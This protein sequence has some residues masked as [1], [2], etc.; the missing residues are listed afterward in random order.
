MGKK[1]PVKKIIT[2]M[3]IIIIAIVVLTYLGRVEPVLEIVPTELNFGDMETKKSFTLLNKGKEKWKILSNVK[4]LQYEID[5]P[6]DIEWI[7]IPLKSGMC[8]K[9]EEKNVTVVINRDKLSVGKNM[10][11]IEAKS[12]GGNKTI[13]IVAERIK[14]EK[15]IKIMRPHART[16]LLMDNEVTIQWIATAN[17]GNYVDILLLLNDSIIETIVKSYNYRNDDTSDG[18]YKWTPKSP[19][20]PGEEKY[21]IRIVDSSDKN[22]FADV[23]LIQIVSPIT[24]LFLKN[25][26]TAHQKPST[27]QFIFSLRDQNNRAVSINPSAFDL[28]NLKIWE[29]NEEID[30]HE[31]S[32]FLYTQ[33]DFQM[34]V[35]LVLDFSAS[36]QKQPNGVETM[37]AGANSLIDNL[38]E[39]HQIGIVE[40]HRPDEAPS[41]I[42]PFTT[43]KQHAKESIENFST[44]NI[45]SDFSICWDAAYQ[46]LKQ[47]PTG[48]DHKIFRALVFISDGFDNSSL[49]QPEDLILLANKE[50]IHIYN[51]GLGN[52]RNESILENI[53]TKT[54]GTYIRAE[55][56][57]FF[58]ERFKQIIDDLGGQYKISYIT[59][60]R[61]EDGIFTVKGEITY[62]GVTGTPPLEDL[63]DPS[64]IFGKTNQGVISFE[65]SPFIKGESAEIFMWCEHTPRYVSTFRFFL[66][67]D[68]PYTISLVPESD[69]GI[70]KGW[71]IIKAEDGWYQLNSPNPRDM[72]HD[73]E[74][75]RSGIICKIIL[76]EIKEKETE[77]SFLLD[78][79]VYPRRQTFYGRDASE[80]DTNK[81]WSKTLSISKKQH[82]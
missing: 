42:Q 47:F 27:I 51:I 33:D 35:M 62:K 49:K 44:K 24:K 30:Y 36:M 46:G 70:C 53:S 21:T 8:E 45:Y 74:F 1:S 19:L 75:G 32:P 82:L 59:P 68:T 67:T 52:I 58:L 26:T 69:G 9:Q 25:I 41:I 23:P 79:S 71:N 40:F 72:S 11:T 64:L 18:N 3:G 14:E 43:N 57:N 50:D 65:I 16:S 38:K 56:M 22:V 60:K 4:T 28:R 29:N 78:N 6:K 34:Q 15:F 73:L 5:I 80:I 63:V 37:L 66:K 39:T 10:G 61:P 31:S 2:L 55:N 12:N 77:V 76:D 17:I 7:S 48:P 20:R 13:N 54:G 81:N